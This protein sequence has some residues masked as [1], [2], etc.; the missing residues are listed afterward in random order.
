MRASFTRGVTPAGLPEGRAETLELLEPH[1]EFKVVDTPYG[2]MAGAHRPAEPGKT[3]WR[4]TQFLFPFFSQ[5][6]PCPLGSEAIL[7]GWVPMDDTHTM[8][9]SITT[10]TFSISRN[11]RATRRPIPQRGLTYDYEFLPNTTGWYG[12][13]R[14]KANRANDHLIDRAVQ[15]SE[16]FSGIEGLDIQDTAITESM[17]LVVDHDNET[18]VPSDL[19][20]ARMRR[21]LLAAARAFKS[22]ERRLPASTSPGS[23][24]RCLERLHSR[25]GGDGLSRSLR[26]AHPAKRREGGVTVM[27]PM[28]RV[29]SGHHNV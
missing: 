26:Q 24:P 29:P 27:R 21:R 9:F 14:L 23:L 5:V 6:P 10:D 12:R 19:L 3:Y 16:S 28:P 25:A 7:R 1:A 2:V 4:F 11:P 20:V 13:W 15:R 17:G 18:L 8:Y 22:T